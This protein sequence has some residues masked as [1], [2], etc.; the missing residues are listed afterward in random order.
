MPT[1]KTN[2]SSST[3]RRDILSE[4]LSREKNLQNNPYTSA[5]S[6]TLFTSHSPKQNLSSSSLLLHPFV[7]HA[8]I[9][10]FLYWIHLPSIVA[11]LTL[12]HNWVH[13]FPL[14]P[15]TLSQPMGSL[16]NY[17]LL[18]SLP[19]FTLLQPLG[20]PSPFSSLSFY[21]PF[22]LLSVSLSTPSLI[23]SMPY[24]FHSSTLHTWGSL[25]WSSCFL[26]LAGRDVPAIQLFG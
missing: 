19:P 6:F 2:P 1:S 25:Q 7:S 18:S 22:P 9:S 4:T 10:L 23:L 12:S 3:L 11:P 17:P 15:F 8:P 20:L 13:L 26:S 24:T 21:S 5:L 16:I 14:S